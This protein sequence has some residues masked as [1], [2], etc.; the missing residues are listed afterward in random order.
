MKLPIGIRISADMIGDYFLEI[1]RRLRENK[2][3]GGKIIKVTE[4]A[5]IPNYRCIF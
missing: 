2:F 4:V 5:N 3:V 1:H